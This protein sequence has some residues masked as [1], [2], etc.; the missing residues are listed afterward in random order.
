[1]KVFLSK[2]NE[3]TLAVKLQYFNQNDVAKIRQVPGRK[4]IPEEAVWTVP[5]TLGVIEHCI[6]LFQGCC[7][8]VEPA[9]AEECDM[10]QFRG[11]DLESTRA[12]LATPSLFDWNDERKTQLKNELMMRGYSS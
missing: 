1:M 11:D 7:M 4:W 6:D 12:S 5:Y 10:L 9:L 3:E 2:R 8:E